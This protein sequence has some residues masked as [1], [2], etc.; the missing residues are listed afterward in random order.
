MQVRD[1]K[2]IRWS[3]WDGEEE[4]FT[5]EV[6]V[7]VQELRVFIKGSWVFESDRL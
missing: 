1:N 5:M 2:N 6:L 7:S 3:S 4:R